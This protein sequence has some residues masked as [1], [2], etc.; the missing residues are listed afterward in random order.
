MRW[1]EEFVETFYEVVK[2]EN[3]IFS[4]FNENVNKDEWIPRSVVD[5]TE[6]Q[7]QYLLF[8]GLL[9]NKYFD[10]WVIQLEQAYSG[11]RHAKSR[12]RHAD[13]MLSK[14]RY[15]KPDYESTICIEMKPSFRGV[16]DDYHRLTQYSDPTCRGLLVYKF[17]KNPV[18]LADKINESPEF[19]R[20]KFNKMTAPGHTEVNVVSVGGNH[21]R[22]HFEAVLLSW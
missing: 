4:R 17:S 9:V 10:G 12:K 8:K 3:T 11:K 16:E 19:S 18:E 13:F 15:R 1:Q 2:Q 21:E 22:Y 20:K 7:W 6:G 5:L 14:I